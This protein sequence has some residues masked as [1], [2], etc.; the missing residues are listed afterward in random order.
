VAGLL[1]DEFVA[2]ASALNFLKRSCA[3]RD[4]HRLVLYLDSC[5]SG[6]WAVKAQRLRLPNVIVQTACSDTQTT[7]DGAFTKVFVDFQNH[8]VDMPISTQLHSRTPFVYVP[9]WQSDTVVYK[10]TRQGR[11]NRDR[12]YMH[13]LSFGNVLR[14]PGLGRYSARGKHVVS[15]STLKLSASHP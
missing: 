13:L 5:F 2:A 12:P 8:P 15:A 10:A 1:D 4:G 11:A 7:L 9:W 3:C 6:H 14:P